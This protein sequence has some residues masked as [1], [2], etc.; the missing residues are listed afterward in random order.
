[1]TLKL[2]ITVKSLL[3]QKSREEWK[4]VAKELGYTLNWVSMVANGAI[5]EPS[6]DK[7]EQLYQLLTGKELEL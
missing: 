5:K 2:L 7:I 4:A 3:A 1:M 6:V